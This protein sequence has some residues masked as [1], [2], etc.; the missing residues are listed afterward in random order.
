MAK[1][2]LE[3]EM[4]WRTIEEFDIVVIKA[5]EERGWRRRQDETNKQTVIKNIY[6]KMKTK[7]VG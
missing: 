7:L 4:S 3:N 6:Y 2:I 5:K 1:K